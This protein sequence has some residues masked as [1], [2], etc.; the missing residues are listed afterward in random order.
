MRMCIT[1]SKTIVK[2]AI[3]RLASAF[4]QYECEHQA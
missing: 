4:A 2:E 3:D 1:T